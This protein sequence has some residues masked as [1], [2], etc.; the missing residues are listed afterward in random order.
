MVVTK[1]APPTAANTNPFTVCFNQKGVNFKT[2][3]ISGISYLWSSDNPSVI[4]YGKRNINTLVDFPATGSPF[5]LYITAINAGGCRDSVKIV[6]TA[7]NQVTNPPKVMLTPNNKTLVC[8]DN[9][10]TT[11]QWGYDDKV[12]FTAT[13]ISGATLQDYTPAGGF[14]FGG[15]N[16]YVKLNSGACS[17]K[18]YYNA[19][20]GLN[21]VSA[22]DKISIYPN[23]NNGSFVLNI[24]DES[25]RG[26][27]TDMQ[28]RQL[29][30]ITLQAGS[31]NIN[32]PGLSSG[33]YYLQLIDNSGK[34]QSIKFIINK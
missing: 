27:V 34:I 7:T 13:D 17:Y 21:K 8:L 26:V 1:P 2:D 4:I 29:H 9:S 19:P 18:V 15:K 20:T 22:E 31:N 10:Q 3:S 5:N 23:P 6:I 12:S 24:T 11:Y 25:A 32:M 14:D 28:G 16:Y 30:F 33:I